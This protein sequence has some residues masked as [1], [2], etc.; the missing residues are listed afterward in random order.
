M[1]DLKKKLSS[2][3]SRIHFS[4]RIIIAAITLLALSQALGTFIS[5]LTFETILVKTITAKYVIL[6]K[7]L[8]RRI[9][10]SLKFGKRLEHF[11]GMENLVK[12][13]YLQTEDLSEIVVAGITGK[14][15]FSSQRITPIPLGD[16]SS[17]K[18]APEPFRVLDITKLSNL[19]IGNF[20]KE[21]Q[22]A[23]RL[24]NGKYYVLFNIKPAFRDESGILALIFPKS[25]INQK[26]KALVKSSVSKMLIS[27][28][29]TAILMGLM[30]RF[31]FTRPSEKELKTLI[32]K[33]RSGEPIKDQDMAEGQNE[34]QDLYRHIALFQDHALRKKTE[35]EKME[36]RLKDALDETN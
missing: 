35:L 16:P 27:M 29:I 22:P 21:S 33:I 7:D 4:G 8:K 36:Q 25:V 28:S 17:Q 1:S 15:I 30:I 18:D 2:I 13:L 6:G 23:A 14:P 24:H 34:I 12:P 31:F 5:V 20:L 3:N 10:H 26:N 19:P 11:L 9:E 32:Q